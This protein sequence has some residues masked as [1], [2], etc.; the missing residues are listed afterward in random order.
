MILIIL[1]FILGSG[2]GFLL[3][4]KKRIIRFSE[5][6]SDYSVY[7]LLFFLG[8]SVGSS[9]EIISNIGKYGFLSIILTF[10]AVLGS[11]VPAYIYD[12]F[13]L[14]GKNH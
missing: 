9:E 6:A 2:L 13:F 7:I 10:G 4:R 12:K 14:K 5:S 8:V 3:K 11:L 1:F